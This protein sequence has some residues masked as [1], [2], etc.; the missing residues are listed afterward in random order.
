V[1]FAGTLA[2]IIGWSNT[3]IT[4]EVPTDA[5][6]GYVVV[7]VEG[8]D[9]NGVYFTVPG[10]TD[11]TP[12]EPPTGLTA[13]DHPN[14]TGGA[15]D[16]SW[17]PSTS[18]DVAYYGIFRS[19]VP[20]AATNGTLIDTTTGTSYTDINVID[21]TTYYYVVRAY[22]FA[23][24]PGGPNE[25]NPSNEASAYSHENIPPD[26]PTNL[27]ATAGDSIV[28]LTWNASLA[29]DTAGY[30]IYRSLTSGSGYTRVNTTP[31]SETSYRDSNLPKGTTYYYVVKA[32]DNWGNESNPSNEVSAT[33][34]DTVPPNPPT[35]LSAWPTDYAVVLSWD[36]NVE[37]DTAGYNIYRS[38]TSGSNYTFISYTTN[39][40]YTDSGLT[41]GTT[42]YYVITAIDTSGNE[43]SSSAEVWATPY[44]NVAPDP[45]A[46]LEAT[47]TPNDSGGSITLNWSASLATDTAGYHIFRSLTS[48]SG[49][50]Q[51]AT[52]TSTNFTDTNLANDTTYY[53]VITAFDEVP[54]ES[55]YSIEAS[56][57]PLDNLPPATPTITSVIAGNSTIDL[58]WTASP[59][60]DTAGY[61]IWW[62]I[63]SGLYTNVV[64][65][66]N[67][68]SYQLQDLSNGIT[69]YLAVTAYDSSGNESSKSTEVSATPSAPGGGSGGN[70]GS[71]QEDTVPPA[72]PT[73][74]VATA[75]D[76]RVTLT[77][78]SNTE[79][80][81]AGYNIYRNTSEDTATATKL[82]LSSL[83][84]GTSFEDTSVIN[85]QT[86]YYFVSAVDKS[87]NESSLSE[88]VSALP[89]PTVSFSD[90]P[91]SHWAYPYI[92]R[93]AQEG[94]INGYPDGTF[95]PEKSITRAEFAK[96]V[97]LAV[98]YTPTTIYKGYFPDV[99]YN[100]W[101]WSYIE[102]AKELGI[103]KGYPDG[104]FR[105]NEKISRAEITKMAV[106]AAGYSISTFGFPFPDVPWSHWAYNYVM[107][108]RN[109]K[110]ISGYPDG[111][112][113]PE[114][115]AT[116]AEAAKVI[117]EMKY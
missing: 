23:P 10:T 49:Y 58:D 98:G 82:N 11:V 83:I 91:E 21:G 55:T 59:E 53:Y 106:S 14:D 117:Y 17:S 114:G 30:F 93:L 47:D 43:S 18:P 44:D 29:T 27:T 57:T 46:S 54:N 88:P 99:G 42:Y 7:T 38:L 4:A 79:E 56:A 66:G 6:S 69:Y 70:G 61:K 39:T 85:G 71:G 34:F 108:A 65:V 26:A 101:A 109:Q 113:R 24:P 51:I 36:S 48:G 67:T 16:L 76:T 63:Q 102:K 80:D 89:L 112:F 94:I 19:T 40:S 73:G 97:L 52:T 33:P 78:N 87:G 3:Q 75:G 111:T 28:D 62:G 103:I 20:D 81:L 77:W 13:E 72:T 15:I 116:R 64:D 41:N 37:S 90:V 22:D 92:I 9:S 12:P 68:N 86:Y 84:T 100:H 35:G 74:L 105:P 25:S 2:N 95:K 110:I 8:V 31:V 32:V 60:T 45:P 96:I 115:A 1:T 104:L 5:I 107:T 50:V